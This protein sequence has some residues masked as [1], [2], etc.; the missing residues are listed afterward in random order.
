MGRVDAFLKNKNFI[1]RNG[2]AFVMRQED[3][4]DID[5]NIDFE[6]ARLLMKKETDNE[7][8]DGSL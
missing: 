7:S 2:F 4:V 6:I 8:I 3:S 5:S 1:G